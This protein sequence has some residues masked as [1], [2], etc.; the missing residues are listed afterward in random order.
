MLDKLHEGH[1]GVVRCRSRAQS[2][3]WWPGLSRQLEAL[4]RSCTACAVERCNPSEPMIS[5]DTVLRPWQKV[6]TD[7]FVYKQATYLLVVDN[8]SSYVEIAKLAETTS[9]DVILHLR[10]I[11]ARHGIPET[12]V[13]DNGPQYHM[14]LRGLPGKKALYTSLAAHVTLIVM[15]KRNVL[16][17]PLRQC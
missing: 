12:V 13:S 6:G 1:Q 15:A 14:R 7:M 17:R 5:S 2:S 9:P 16:C 10:S 3:V 8:A 11:F 4:V